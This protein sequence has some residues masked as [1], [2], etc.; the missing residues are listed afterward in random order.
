MARR[1]S[2][3]WEVAKESYGR[4]MLDSLHLYERR[5]DAFFLVKRMIPES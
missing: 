3:A 1:R 5:L 2:S 4:S